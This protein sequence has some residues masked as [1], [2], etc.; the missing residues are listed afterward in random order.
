ME[1]LLS[2]THW[3][4]AQEMTVFGAADAPVAHTFKFSLHTG[5]V[6]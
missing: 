4:S 6:E 2:S 5:I 1:V 3:V